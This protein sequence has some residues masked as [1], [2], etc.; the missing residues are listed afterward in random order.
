ME[1]YTCHPRQNCGELEDSLGY[2]ARHS[3]KKTKQN[4]QNTQRQRDVDWGGSDGLGLR[5]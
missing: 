1:T 2:I 3:L 5:P 4:K